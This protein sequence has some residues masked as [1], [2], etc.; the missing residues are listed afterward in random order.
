MQETWIVKRATVYALCMTY[1]MAFH[2]KIVE[3]GVEY[4]KSVSLAV[5]QRL[6][7][8]PYNTHL[9][10]DDRHTAHEEF[11]VHHINYSEQ[12]CENVMKVCGQRPVFCMSCSTWRVAND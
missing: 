7:D 5:D 2:S 8:L 11:Q 9:V 1:S 3:H 4:I 10:C 6:L 12:F